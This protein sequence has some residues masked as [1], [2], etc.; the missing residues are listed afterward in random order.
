[1]IER[2]KLR[3]LVKSYLPQ[4]DNDVIEHIS[5]DVIRDTEAVIYSMVRQAVAQERENLYKKSSKV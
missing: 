3:D 2:D 5:D 1:M 4:V